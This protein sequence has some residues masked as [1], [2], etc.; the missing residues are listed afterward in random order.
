[1][2]FV[3]RAGWR[4]LKTAGRRTHDFPCPLEPQLDLGRYVAPSPNRST[5]PGSNIG[6][7]CHLLAR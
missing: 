1:M 3:P 6:R 4:V 2:L 7:Y 5:A